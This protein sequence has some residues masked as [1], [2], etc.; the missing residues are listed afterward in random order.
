M[1]TLRIYDETCVAKILNKVPWKRRFSEQLSEATPKPEEKLSMYIKIFISQ[2][3]TWCIT[4]VYI[5]ILMIMSA[6]NIPRFIIFEIIVVKYFKQPVFFENVSAVPIAKKCI[7]R[8]HRIS[9]FIWLLGNEDHE[10]Y[11]LFLKR[12]FSIF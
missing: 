9:N 4:S 3:R 5:L 12:T 1:F 8:N 2:S 7:Y 11:I 6:S 10:K